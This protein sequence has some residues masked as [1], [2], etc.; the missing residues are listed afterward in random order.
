MAAVRVCGSLD[1][2]VRPHPLVR[3]DRVDVALA[4]VGENG[5]GRRT[6]LDVGREALQRADD[7]PGGAAGEDRLARQQPAAARHALGVAH[8]YHAI[9][10]GIVVK[11]G[12]ARRA[13]PRNQAGTR[14]RAW[15]RGG[16][17]LPAPGPGTRA[18]PA[19]GQKMALP[20]ASTG[21]KAVNAPRARTYS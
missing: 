15:S 3:V 16:G 12:A 7:R 19:G 11:G 2:E 21:T 1:S 20:S 4:A 10:E 8:Q 6:G 13:V 18:E 17:R 9:G 14:G 5:Y